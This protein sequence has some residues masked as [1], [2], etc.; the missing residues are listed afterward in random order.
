MFQYAAG[1]RLALYR[2]V[3]LKLDIGFYKRFDSRSYELDEFC[4][5]EKIAA[6]SEIRRLRYGEKS[7]WRLQSR[8]ARQTAKD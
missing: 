6:R 1:K 5:T 3:E 4:I 7:W 2:G 8:K